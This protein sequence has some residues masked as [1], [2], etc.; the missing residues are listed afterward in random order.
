MPG[1]LSKSGGDGTRG[2]NKK[3]TDQAA[4]KRNEKLV[5]LDLQGGLRTTLSMEEL[6]DTSRGPSQDKGCKPEKQHCR[7]A[8]GD[9]DSENQALGKKKKDRAEKSLE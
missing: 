8:G 3:I 5:Q 6:T 1:T 9:R 4:E 2:P 7:N